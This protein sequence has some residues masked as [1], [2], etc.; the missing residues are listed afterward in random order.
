M[1]LANPYQVPR[2]KDLKETI[3]DVRCVDQAGKH[4]I[5]EMQVAPD[6]SFEKRVLMYNSKAYV[7]QLGKGRI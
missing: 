7:Q 1:K 2:T 5:V 6:D 3:L 4:F